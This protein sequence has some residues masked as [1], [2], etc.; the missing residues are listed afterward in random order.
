[1]S[2]DQPKCIDCGRF[3]KWEDTAPAIPDR[4]PH[5]TTNSD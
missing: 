4:C 1:M 5:C 2:Y 3:V